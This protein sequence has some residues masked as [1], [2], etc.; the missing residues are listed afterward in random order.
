MPI[1]A[2]VQFSLQ[3]MIQALE[4]GALAQV[5][6]KTITLTSIISILLD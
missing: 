3:K 5:S 1:Q 2:L 6:G 4:F